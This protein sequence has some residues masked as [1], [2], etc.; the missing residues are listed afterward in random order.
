MSSIRKKFLRSPFQ[1]PFGKFTFLLT[2]I[3]LFTRYAYSQNTSVHI[4][5]PVYR[6]L[7]LESA[8]GRLEGYESLQLPLSNN[9]VISLLKKIN[10]DTLGLYD[11]ASVKN[12]F[13]R[14]FSSTYPENT[15]RNEFT[16]SDLFSSDEKRHFYEYADSILTFSYDFIGTIKNVNTISEK[17]QSGSGLFTIGGRFL[18]DFPNGIGIEYSVYNGFVMGSRMSAVYDRRVSNSFTFQQTG[19]NNFDGTYGYIRYSSPLFTLQAG[20]EQITW[21]RSSHEPMMIGNATQPLD[22][23]RMNLNYG[24]LSYSF[25]HAWLVEKPVKDSLIAFPGIKPEKAIAISRLGFNFSKKLR[26]GIFAAIVYANRTFEAAY[27]NPFIFHESAQRSLN[28][29]DN[30][31]LGLDVEYKPFKG[32]VLKP[33]ILLDDFNLG[34][35][36]EEGITS[37]NNGMLWSI[38][39]DLSGPILPYNVL[40]SATILE[41][42]PFTFTHPAPGLTLAYTNNDRPLGVNAEPNSR[43]IAISID[44]FP[45]EK[46][47][48]TPF[49]RFSIH[50]DNEYDS[51]GKLVRN[52]GGE[53]QHSYSYYTPFRLKI[54]DGIREYKTEYGL[55]IIYRI[56]SAIICS[57]NYQYSL[58]KKADE[59]NSSHFA[60]FG[61]RFFD[62]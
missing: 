21:G 62:F 15:Y 56:S 24:I 43:V 25:L 61:L 54:L 9:Q 1:I 37:R 18:L 51:S 42:R 26:L 23:I 19:I 3:F 30:S 14:E 35:W 16:P 55:D 58:F 10:P 4:S 20:R 17:R 33:E 40:L 41:I 8:S 11:P 38:S 47:L 44:Y 27:L 59:Q 13:I 22:F 45:S 46:I 7:A 53:F 48:V 2:V 6:Y 31:F 12:S 5:H 28:D 39:L 36:I 49:Y 32:L 50:G 29:V 34:K 60:S 52:V 57:F